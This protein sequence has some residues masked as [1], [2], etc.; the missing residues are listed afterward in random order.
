MR[1]YNRNHVQCIALSIGTTKNHA[2][3]LFDAK[4]RQRDGTETINGTDLRPLCLPVQSSY[5]G[6]VVF[7][8]LEESL[9]AGRTMSSRS[10]IFENLS[11]TRDNTLGSRTAGTTRW[12]SRARE[13]KKEK[14][15][16]RERERLRHGRADRKLV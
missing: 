2:V 16:E 13:R 9:A 7:E 1:R 14:E 12:N 8:S 10:E 15:R 5:R 6:E 4:S 3:T 11:T